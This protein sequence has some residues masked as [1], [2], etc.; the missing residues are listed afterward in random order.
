MAKIYVVDE[1]MG[2]G[3]TSAM[4]NHIN[5]NAGERYIYIT[6]YLTEV[7]RVQEACGFGQPEGEG[8][9]LKSF[10]AMLRRGES[11]VTTHALFGM[12]DQETFG[13]IRQIGYTLVMDEATNS[14]ISA[15]RVTPDDTKMVE[16]NFATVRA[17]GRLV[18]TE[19]NYNGVYGELRKCIESGSV[20]KFSENVWIDMV[21]PDFLW[22]FRE[23]YIMTYLFAGQTLKYYLDIHGITYDNLYV[24]GNNTE[25][26]AFTDTSQSDG[27][28]VDAG[29][30]KIVE[31]KRMN[32][33]GDGRCDLSKAWY[34]RHTRGDEMATLKK[35]MRNFFH[36]MMRCKSD[37]TL[38]TCF[39]G[40]DDVGDSWKRKLSGGGY[41][42][43]FLS[44]NARGT[45]MYA[46]RNALAYMV[47]RFPDMRVR[48]FLSAKGIR[49]DPDTFAL[50]EMVQW[51][52]RSSIRRGEPITLY[53]PSAR[54]RALFTA[55]LEG[56]SK[57]A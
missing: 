9:K 36:N 25:N 54:M 29:L 52:W 38:W 2:R 37:E 50:A 31:N 46:D 15:F 49:M 45:N 6:P 48:N 16:Q 43:G 28:V 13:L 41:N 47:N 33:V 8:F 26:Y 14:V 30:I 35:H 1:I 27:P 19:P 57:T 3:K 42:K 56:V 39:C 11:I 5:A 24:R 55:W 4:I 23:V 22:A 17:D 32:E 12:L 7:A 40:E 21:P 51:V 34:M 44:C 20:Y 10:K 18:W 53:V